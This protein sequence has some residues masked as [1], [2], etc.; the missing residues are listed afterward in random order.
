[1]TALLGLPECGQNVGQIALDISYFA[2]WTA[3]RAA[4]Q[5]GTKG[6]SRIMERAIATALIAECLQ[7]QAESV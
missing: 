7:G 3:V 6:S 5:C 1:V 4:F 2:A